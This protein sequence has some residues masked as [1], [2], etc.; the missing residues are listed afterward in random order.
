ME[1]RSISPFFFRSS[2]GVRL[3][4]WIREVFLFKASFGGLPLIPGFTA[5]E[6]Y[7]VNIPWEVEKNKTPPGDPEM[8]YAFER[9]F[10]PS[11][12][13]ECMV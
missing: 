13:Y 2:N 9:V 4:W 7:T 5:G 8:L 12:G 10:M 6:G 11:L 3:N 1:H